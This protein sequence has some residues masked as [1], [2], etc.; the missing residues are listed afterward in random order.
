MVDVKKHDAFPTSLYNFEHKFASGEL[1]TLVDY[2]R[3]K[4]FVEKNGQNLSHLGARWNSRTGSQL[5]NEIHKL[6][7]FSNLVKTIMGVTETI[8]EDKT[9]QGKPE[10]TNMWANILRPT[11]QKFHAPHTHSNNV[12]SGVLYLKASSK[13]SAIQFFDPRPQASVFVPRR[14]SDDFGNS[15]MIAYDSKV[16]TGIIFPSW[17]QHWVPATEDERISVA[18]NVLVRGEYGEPEQLQNAHI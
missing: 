7:I 3:E 1:K 17:L 13:T 4:S 12:F 8:M 15:D 10:I 16:G 6:D 11:G 14:S 18:W 5:E 9:Y 2:I